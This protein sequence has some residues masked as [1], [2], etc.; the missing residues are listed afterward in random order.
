ML[1]TIMVA[2]AVSFYA[3]FEV[4]GQDYLHGVRTSFPSMALCLE[5]EEDITAKAKAGR[6]YPLV[7]VESSCEEEE[8]PEEKNL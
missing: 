3:A 4:P 8:E 7:L 2:G 6:F 1:T 5:F